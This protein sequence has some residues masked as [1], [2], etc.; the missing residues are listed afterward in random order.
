MNVYLGEC[1]IC[2]NVC[3][4]TL[5]DHGICLYCGQM[6]DT[7]WKRGRLQLELNQYHK[8]GKIDKS[9]RVCRC[10]GSK[11]IDYRQFENSRGLFCGVTCSD[12]FWDRLPLQRALCGEIQAAKHFKEC[13][14]RS[15]LANLMI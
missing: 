3:Q 5:G 9:L 7:H 6:Y 2:E 13:G 12:N 1:S 15:A 11:V 14:G 4:L 10:C 8:A